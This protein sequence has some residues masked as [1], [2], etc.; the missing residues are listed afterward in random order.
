MVAKGRG[1]GTE[2]EKLVLNGYG[3]SIL[4]NEKVLKIC[5]TTM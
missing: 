5:C 1:A 4:Q 2:E 3:S